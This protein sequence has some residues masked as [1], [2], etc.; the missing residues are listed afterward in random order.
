[1]SKSYEKIFEKVLKKIKP[2]KDEK[3]KMENLA[4]KSLGIAEKEAKK[5]SAKAMLAGSITRDTWLPGKLEFDVFILFP[6]EMDEKDM[7]KYGLEIGKK[8][9]RQLKGKWKIEY[10]EHPYVHGEAEGVDID[11]VPAYELK[12]LEKIK[13]AVDRTPFHVR[14]MEKNLSINQSDQVR[15]LK[16][17]LKAI[18]AY[19]ADAK[20]LG[21]SGYSCEL[22]II[23]Y[24]NFL[25]TLKAISKWSPGEIIDIENFYNP[26]DYPKLRKNFKYHPLILIDPTDKNRNTASALST[27]KFFRIIKHAK[28]FL[29]APSENLFF[30][31][32]IKPITEKELLKHL[33]HRKTQ[34]LII[35]FTPPKAV[36]DVIWPQ[37]RKFANRLQSIL[38]ETKYEFK[39]F[40]KDVYTNEKDL[41]IVLLEM[42]IFELPFIQ[43]R[44]GPIVFD[45]DDSKRFLDKY[46]N[47]ALSLYVENNFWVAE[48]RRKFLTAKDKLIDSLNKDLEILKAKGIPNLIAEQISKKGFQ[49]FYGLKKIYNLTK[50]DKNFGM[51]L[52]NYFE[53]ESLV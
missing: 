4:R 12:S 19:G 27:E 24:K 30:K 31:K 47:S 49:V 5:F 39:V 28:N 9:I 52:R 11:I 43:K 48:I 17:F 7:E 22:L 40:G 42:E 10:A 3:E 53:K 29:E 44:I 2:K 8:V 51:F 23:K 25:E 13:S 38:E 34:L 35:K 33:K 15:L 16:Q 1:M 50:K 18:D 46:K 37:L 20:T 36:P 41:A 6:E 32:P 14:Y 26:K 45:L 21:L